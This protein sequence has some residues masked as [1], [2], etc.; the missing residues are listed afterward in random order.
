MTL[1]TWND[2]YRIGPGLID[3]EHQSLFQMINE[4]HTHWTEKHDTA[5][6]IPILN[7]LIRYAQKHFRDEEEIMAA[8]DYPQLE[9]HKTFHNKLIEE[10]FALQQEFEKRNVRLEHDLQKFLKHWLF[11]HVISSDYEFRDYLARRAK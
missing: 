10:I 8:A 7:R 4:F 5:L 1:L 9:L 6:I 3:E 11:D 2:Q